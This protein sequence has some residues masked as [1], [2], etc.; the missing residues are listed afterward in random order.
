MKAKFASRCGYC[1]QQIAVG[2]PIGRS[3]R[4]A[5]WLHEAC[6][7]RSQPSGPEMTPSEFAARYATRPG[8]GSSPSGDAR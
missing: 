7:E 5:G 1:G 4:V 8:E 6:V 3:T 2:E